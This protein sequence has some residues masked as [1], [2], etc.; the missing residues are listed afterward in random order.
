MVEPGLLAYDF[1][2]GLFAFFAPCGSAML[3]A[4]LAYYLPRGNGEHAPPIA[5]RIAQGLAGG[6][7]AALGAFLVLLAI[8][9]L[10]VTLGAPFKENVLWL[11]LFGGIVVIVL[12]TLMIL[13]RGPSLKLPVRASQKKGALSLIGFGALYAATASSCVAAVFLAVLIPAFSAPIVDGILQVGAYALGLSVVLLAASV[14]VALSQGALVRAMRR[15]VPHIE[16]ASGALLVAAG[17][18]LV[19][20]WAAA[21]YGFPAPPS[22]PTP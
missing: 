22:L 13:G 19:W 2:L 10:A 15:V 11:E 8:G 21:Q 3:P 4:Y 20:Y 18:Y 17:L 7:L 16:K 1:T 9:A 14:L 5:T 12:G 6:V